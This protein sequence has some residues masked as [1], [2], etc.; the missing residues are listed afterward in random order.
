[1]WGWWIWGYILIYRDEVCSKLS[2]VKKCQ[3]DNSWEPGNDVEMLKCNPCNFTVYDC[4]SCCHISSA[5]VDHWDML[6]NFCFHVYAQKSLFMIVCHSVMSCCHMSKCLCWSLGHAEQLLFSCLGWKLSV[7]RWK[8]QCF[9]LDH[10]HSHSSHTRAC[11]FGS[12]RAGSQLKTLTFLPINN[13]FS[14]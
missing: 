3:N 12:H 5:Y 4:L 11:E 13:H 8:W 9:F 14:A 2:T 7:Y 1:M 6:N 10:H